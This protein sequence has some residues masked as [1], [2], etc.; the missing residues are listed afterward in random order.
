MTLRNKVKVELTLKNFNLP[1]LS[2]RL[3]Y[4]LV[5]DNDTNQRRCYCAL[6]GG[7]CDDL[8]TLD[9]GQIDL[10]KFQLA[11]TIKDTDL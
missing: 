6:F 10:P 9:Q 11:V 7:I 3:R 4:R 8:E 2:N 5:I 1:Y